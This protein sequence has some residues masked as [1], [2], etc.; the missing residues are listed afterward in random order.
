MWIHPNIIE[1]Q[2]SKAKIS[3][4]SVVGIS[5]RETEE[6][7]ASLPSSGEEESAFVADTSAP[8]TLKTRSGKPY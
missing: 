3:S 1:S 4:N 5:T 8:L 2:Q 7:V 6:D